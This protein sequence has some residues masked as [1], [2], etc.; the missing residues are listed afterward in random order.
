MIILDNA[1]KPLDPGTQQEPN[2]V[3]THFVTM[4]E[5]ILNLSNPRVKVLITSRTGMEQTRIYSQR[6]HCFRLDGENEL[7][8]EDAM[9]IIKYHAGKTI[10]EDKDAQDLADLCGKIPL[11]MK[12]V[13]SRFQDGTISPK[14]M[15]KHLKRHDDAQ[16]QRLVGSL[17]HLGLAKTDQLTFSLMNTIQKLPESHQRNIIR[18]SVIPGSFD[19]RAAQEIL[20]YQKKDRVG[21][22]LDLQALKYRSLLESDVEDISK[23][24]SSEASRYSMHLL[25]RSFL[26]HLCA[27]KSYP[28]AEEYKKGEKGFMKHFGK[29][30]QR[31]AKIFQ[32]DFVKALAS[33]QD[34]KANFMYLLDCFK[35]KHFPSDEE[36]E[37]LN[38]AVEL[39]MVPKERVAFYRTCKNR[40]KREGR[41]QMYAEFCCHETQQLVD[42]G[43]DV[44]TIMPLFEE[45]ENILKGL[46]DKNTHSAQLSL[47]TLYHFRGNVIAR[48]LKG[49]DALQQ[50]KDALDIRKKI[51]GDHFLTARTINVLGQAMQSAAKLENMGY[52]HEDMLRAIDYYR[53]AIDMCTRITG[54]DKHVDAPTIY[55]NIGACLH[56]MSR[57]GQAV[58]YFKKSL[59]LERQLGMEGTPGTCITLKNIAMS[60]YMQEK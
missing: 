42:L 56:E 52:I 37:W 29:K 50:L 17:S 27:D 10:V 58:E 2:E 31:T 6:L 19:M 45:A 15:I 32:K 43:F 24:K 20:G 41:M 36:N 53:R 49:E 11:A 14:E 23:K 13:A 51:L 9:E 47:A 22:K 8:I 38:L 25:L 1:D 35:E 57:F 21:L 7:D 46:P 60:Y 48:R 40:A 26:Q 54:S 59:D 18:L 28:M 3:Y 5:N 55:L 39:M 12:V 30:M 4:V 33:K 44:E 34:E 16:A